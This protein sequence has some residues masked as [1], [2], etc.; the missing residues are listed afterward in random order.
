MLFLRQLQR[1]YKIISSHLVY[2]SYSNGTLTEDIH[3]EREE[4]YKFSWFSGGGIHHCK[5]IAI[6]QDNPGLPWV[7]FHVESTIDYFVGFLLLS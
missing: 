5:K 3:I 2:M 6:T 7:F 4:N 1:P